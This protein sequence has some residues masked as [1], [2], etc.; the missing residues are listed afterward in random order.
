MT[1]KGGEPFADIRNIRILK[2]LYEV[3]PSC[4][5]YIVSNF[6][7]IT[8]EA[9][10]ILKMTTGHLDV[11]ASIDGVGRVYDWIRSNT[12]EHTIK[13]MERYYKETGLTININVCISLYNFFHLEK[14][15]DYFKDKE[16]I[17]CISFMNVTS[18]PP[19]VDCQLLP[20]KIFNAQIE[21]YKRV[22]YNVNKKGYNAWVLSEP[23]LKQK[24]RPILDEMASKELFFEEL[25]KM[26]KHR[27]FDLCD[28]ITE[29]KEW[30]DSK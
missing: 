30:R 10:E 23:L 1:I 25:D 26:N 21:K 4:R 12:F 6:Y 18:R 20:K 14:I 29:L 22:F 2:K 15:L 16:Y 13:T 27:G 11:S 5:V 9:M 3:N 24:H 8:P 7:T 17:K 19:Y 28:H